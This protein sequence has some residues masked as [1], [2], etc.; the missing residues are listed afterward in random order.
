MKTIGIIQARITSKRL[1]NKILKKLSDCTV[2]ECIIRRARLSNLL[3]DLVLA[4]PDTKPNDIIEYYAKKLNIKYYR[5][6]ENDV[7]DRYYKSAKIFNADIIVRLT[8]DNP[9][10]DGNFID[11]VISAY[12]NS[13][14]DYVAAKP[15]KEWGIPAGLSV[16]VFSFKAIYKAWLEDKN[17]NWREHVTPYIYMNPGLFTI[18]YQRLEKDYSYYRITLD[19]QDDYQL[20]I[21]IFDSFE[22]IYFQWDDALAVLE[23]NIGWHSIN[24]NVKQNIIS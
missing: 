23:E 4:I 19:T 16:E 5:G 21:N 18:K 12:K 6:S 10:V 24:A 17:Y 8:S 1:P 22:N 9:I 3:D 11:L 2:L 15:G 14:Y 7:L 13:S 20:L